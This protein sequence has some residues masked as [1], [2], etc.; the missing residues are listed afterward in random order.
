MCSFHISH[1]LFNVQT[2]KSVTPIPKKSLQ[3]SARRLSTRR[4]MKDSCT[5]HCRQTYWYVNTWMIDL[6]ASV[7]P[8]DESGKNWID[9]ELDGLCR[10]LHLVWEVVQDIFC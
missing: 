7:E 4:M 8:G 5:Q 9:N 1:L 6:N 2:N 3:W 10:H